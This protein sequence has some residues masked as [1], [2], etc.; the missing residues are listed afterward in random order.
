M[1]QAYHSGIVG[2]NSLT[3]KNTGAHVGQNKT[4][5]KISSLCYW[6]NLHKD[7][8]QYISTCECCQRV[9]TT[10]LQKVNEELHS[11]SIPMKPMAQVGIDLM[12]PKPSKGYNYVIMA[13]DYFTKYVEMGALKDKSAESIAIWIYEN[14][15][16]CSGITDIHITDNGTEFV[17]KIL[18]ELYARCNVAHHITS[19]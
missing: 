1:I 6:P 9:N 2:A 14:I 11:I 12:R 18:K 8:A 10:K 7:V 19:P 16:Y 4:M 15:F 17:N 5:A 13:I 3:A